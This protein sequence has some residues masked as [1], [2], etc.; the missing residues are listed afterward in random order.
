M[1]YVFEDSKHVFSVLICFG[2]KRR[3][4]LGI[5]LS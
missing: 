1:S 4:G 3:I 5:K 2:L